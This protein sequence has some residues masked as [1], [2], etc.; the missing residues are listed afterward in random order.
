VKGQPLRFLLG[1][2]T[3]HAPGTEPNDYPKV[4]RADGVV[5][6][7]HR[8][9]AELALGKQL[10]RGARV[11]HADGSKR[12]DA[13]LVICQSESYHQFLHARMRVKAAGGDPN[14]DKICA[15]CKRVLPKSA[16]SGNRT[17]YDRLATD[18]RRCDEMR[19]TGRKT[20]T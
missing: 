1:H 12:H 15:V 19:K 5:V 10:P 11:H 3:K 9:R 4:K 7:M 6:R 13:P 16:F 20:P 14:L 2:A 8:L 17:K 18:C